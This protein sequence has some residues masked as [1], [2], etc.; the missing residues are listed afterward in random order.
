M[1]SL[2]SLK[3]Q[4]INKKCLELE[5]YVKAWDTMIADYLSYHLKTIVEINRF[6]NIKSVSESQ[7]QNYCAKIHSQCN[8]I[9][10]WECNGAWKESEVFDEK[11]NL[12]F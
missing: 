4:Q 10:M 1:V 7:K 8:C 9:A 5:F 11:K 6:I 2:L 3:Y 12:I